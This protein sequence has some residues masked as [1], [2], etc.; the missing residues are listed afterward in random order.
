[1]NPGQRPTLDPIPP[2]ILAWVAAGHLRETDSNPF[3]V[4]FPTF[5]GLGHAHG[6]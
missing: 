2:K 6:L 1:M 4:E 5:C 3:S